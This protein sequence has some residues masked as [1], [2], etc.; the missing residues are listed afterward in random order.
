MKTFKNRKFYWDFGGQWL[1]MVDYVN[2]YICAAKRKKAW[3]GKLDPS[4]FVMVDWDI[5]L[6]KNLESPHFYSASLK[7]LETAKLYFFFRNRTNQIWEY[8]GIKYTFCTKLYDWDNCKEGDKV[9]FSLNARQEVWIVKKVQGGGHCLVLASVYENYPELVNSYKMYR[10]NCFYTFLHLNNSNK[11]SV[12][13]YS[14][15]D[16]IDFQF[17]RKVKL[18]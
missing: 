18:L 7:D 6:I 2:A 1:Y 9:F 16:I 4:T 3:V 5:Q 15:E 17:L 8:G 12:K 10:P 13:S 14:F 11:F